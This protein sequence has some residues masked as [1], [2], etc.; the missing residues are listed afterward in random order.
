MRTSRNVSATRGCLL[1]EEQTRRRGP[2]RLRSVMF[3]PQ[4]ATSTRSSALSPGPRGVPARKLPEK[5]PSTPRTWPQPLQ[6]IRAALGTDTDLYLGG[7]SHVEAGG[8][9]VLLVFSF[10]KWQ[11]DPFLRPRDVSL[12]FIISFRRT[13]QR[14]D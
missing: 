11:G 8:L 9:V 1:R 13:K 10:R 14:N 4:A 2:P 6:L 3:L 7:F 5:L 12:Y